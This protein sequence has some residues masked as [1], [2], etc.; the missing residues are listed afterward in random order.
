M[1]LRIIRTGILDTVQDTGRWGYQHL[2]I[3]P[4]GAMDRFSACLANALLGNELHRPVFEFHFPAAQILFEE[5]T[6]IC[7]TGGDF[8]PTINNDPVP[9][10][11]PVVVGANSLLRFNHLVSGARAYVSVMHDL[12]LQEWNGSYST[13]LKAG[14]GGLEGKPFSRYDAISFENRIALQEILKD[15]DFVV[16]P[17]K[18]NETVDNRNEIEFVIGSEWHWLDREMQEEFQGHWFQITNEADRMGYRLAGCRLK[19]NSDEQLISSAACFGTVQLLPDGQ[20]IILMADHQTTGGYP[21]I[22]HVISA[23]LP[24]LAQKKPNDVMRF[25]MTDLTTA[26][27]KMERQQKYLGEIQIACKFRIENLL[28]ADL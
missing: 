24:I 14:V 28:H 11:H 9:L 7:I 17:W 23:H 2:G 13:N 1:S 22:A 5:D 18:A 10:H 15:K 12:S 26:E 19:A 16:L 20:L 3:N 8:S 21:K 27:A 25:V 4:G 6:I